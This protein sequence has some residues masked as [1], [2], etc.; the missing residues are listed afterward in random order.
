MKITKIILF[1][2]TLWVLWGIK[3]NLMVLP[4]SIHSNSLL[5]WLLNATSLCSFLFLLGISF[6]LFRLIKTFSQNNFFGNESVNLVRKIGVFVLILAILEVAN[7]TF[8]N[9]FQNPQLLP[10]EVLKDFLWRITFVSPTFL[11]CSILI[12][13]FAK[14]MQRAIEIKNDNETII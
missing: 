6:L 4:I 11:F 2:I 1:A 5:I 3:E 12:F 13:I 14:F 7:R 9:F 10:I 8:Y